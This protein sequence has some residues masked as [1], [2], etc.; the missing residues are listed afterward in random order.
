MIDILKKYKEAI[1]YIIFGGLTFVTNLLVYMICTRIFKFDIYLSNFIAWTVSVLFAYVTNKFFVFES[2]SISF[3]YIIKELCSFM[4][5]RVLT[6]V[7][8]MIIIFLMLTIAGMND[9]FVK[10]VANVV[11]IISNYIF[12]KLIIFTKKDKLELKNNIS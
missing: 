3:K 7:M 2:N 6:G 10:I 11:V 4:G 1:L 9:L 8:E 12:S 5:C